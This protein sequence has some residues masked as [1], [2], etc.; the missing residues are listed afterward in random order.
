M[1]ENGTSIL[2]HDTKKLQIR[3]G[4]K[5]DNEDTHPEALLDGQPGLCGLG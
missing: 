3:N 5:L 2:Y 4:S 1:P